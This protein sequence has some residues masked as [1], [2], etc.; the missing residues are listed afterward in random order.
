MID[1]I[2]PKEIIVEERSNHQQMFIKYTMGTLVD[3]V[4]LGLCNQYSSYVTIDS[5]SLALLAAVLLQALLQI[6]LVIEHR[7]SNYF[8]TKSGTRPK[9]MRILSVWSVLF[10]SKLLILEAISFACGEHVAFHGWW[11][12]VVTFIF[13]VIAILLAEYLVKRIYDS[14]A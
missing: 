8:K 11:H 14:L 5:F 1:K 2:I 7:I 3:L 12:G 13:V 4:V 9:V 10:G 6:T